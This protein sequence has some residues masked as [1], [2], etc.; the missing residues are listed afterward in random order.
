MVAVTGRIG[1]DD[2]IDGFE[3]L[4][5]N[6]LSRPQTETIQMSLKGIYPIWC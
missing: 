2:R 5:D 1:V 6:L 4:F 3:T